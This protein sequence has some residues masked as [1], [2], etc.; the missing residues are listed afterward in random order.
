MGFKLIQEET[1]QDIADAIRTKTENYGTPI[2]GSNMA[3]AIRDIETRI[4]DMDSLNL[5]FGKTEPENKD[6]LWIKRASKPDEV[7]ITDN[8]ETVNNLS[9]LNYTLYSGFSAGGCA[10]VGDTVYFFGG[11]TGTTSASNNITTFNVRTKQSAILSATLPVYYYNTAAVAVGTDIYILGRTYT[12]TSVSTSSSS[13][14]GYIYKFNTLTNEITKMGESIKDPLYNYP[15][16][17]A[18]NY[19]GDIY[20]A[21]HGGGLYRYSVE[22]DEYTT[23]SG[24]DISTSGCELEIVNNRI[25]LI[26]QAI[27]NNIRMNAL[28]EYNPITDVTTLLT[29]FERYSFGDTDNFMYYS[30]AS[31][32]DKIYTFG[33]NIVNYNGFNYVY[34]INT[35]DLSLQKLDFTLSDKC[36]FGKALNIDDTIY[37]FGGRNTSVLNTIHTFNEDISLDNNT[38]VLYV[39]SADSTAESFRIARGRGI[40]IV[41]KI[42]YAYIGNSFNKAEQITFYKYNSSEGKWEGKGSPSSGSGSGVSNDVEF[43]AYTGGKGQYLTIETTGERYKAGFYM[44]FL[45]HNPEYTLEIVDESG[46]TVKYDYELAPVAN[47]GDTYG[48]EYEN[49]LQYNLIYE[50]EDIDDYP[51]FT[52][53]YKDHPELG[54]WV[55]SA[56][57]DMT[58]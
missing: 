34:C 43:V 28:Y 42:K 58:I 9:K 2:K 12:S 21:T 31:I 55:I 51:M 48:E 13:F 41:L 24:I 45:K 32:G 20:F 44:L 23:L 11:N 16:I 8:L 4:F 50:F 5:S 1:L 10:Q 3:Q 40:D 35:L 27:K 6:Y 53:Q 7:R 39:D 26:S 37:I 29:I 25:F 38:C 30:H 57:P 52:V 17:S 14:G 49:V 18:A 22:N 33:G 54:Q 56:Y 15:H 19:N 46:M 36:Y 47:I